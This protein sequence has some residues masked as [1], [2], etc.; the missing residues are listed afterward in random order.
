MLRDVP[1]L[2]EIAPLQDLTELA[3]STQGPGPFP[4]DDAHE[5]DG[6]FDGIVRILHRSQANHVLL[7][8]ERGVGKNTIVAELARRGA[9]GQPT[10]LAD[11]R[12]ITIDCRYVCPDDSRRMIV[13]ILNHVGARPDLVVAIDGFAS[14]L[15]SERGATNKPPSA[16][17]GPRRRAEPRRSGGRWSRRP[18]LWALLRYAAQGPQARAASRRSRT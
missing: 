4:F 14:L 13:G 1:L 15:N 5:Y 2:A 7:V 10:F 16:L 3:R 18:A 6:L 8:G 11:K 17:A 12:I 9:N